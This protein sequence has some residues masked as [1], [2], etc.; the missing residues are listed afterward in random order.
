M[1]FNYSPKIVTNGLV[2]YLD[3]ANI[4]SYVSGSTT[5]SDISR[6][7]NNGTLTNGPT[8]NT[9]SGGNIVFD[10]TN[11]Y[12]AWDVSNLGLNV[13]GPYTI[14]CTL[15]YNSTT[16]TINPITLT[17]L[18]T[19]AFQFGYISS[20]PVVWKYGG[21]T[22]LTYTPP[23]GIY[24][25]SCT[26]TTSLV[27]VYINGILNNS[28]S[29]PSLQTGTLTYLLSSAYHNGTAITP[30]AFFNGNIYNIKLYNKLLTSTEILQNYNATK[31]RF[32]LT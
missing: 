23:S 26:V 27:S 21:T 18:N 5:W 6:G 1:A 24:T 17:S 22:I 29:T 20:S 19:K 14:E 31:T 9:G 2:L 8:F 11:D 13:Q 25:M 32:G 15:R 7:G 4:K 12:A 3:A 10:G 28:T 30:F 16:G